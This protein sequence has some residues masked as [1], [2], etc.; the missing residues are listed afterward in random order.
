MAQGRGNAAGFA[1]A[2]ML[3]LVVLQIGAAQA[4]IHKVGDQKGWTYNVATWPHRKTFKA[5][6]KLYF[7]YNPMFHNVIAVTKKGYKKCIVPKGAKVYNK[8]VDKIKLVKGP[9]YFI[10]GYP[11]HCQSGMKLAIY[12][13]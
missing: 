1:V 6:D 8:G 3:C 2:I 10:C 9:N 13:Q 7:K 4:K 5:G 11:Q 12:A